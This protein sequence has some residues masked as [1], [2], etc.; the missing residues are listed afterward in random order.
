MVSALLMG[1]T[2][3]VLA[4][5]N[6]ETLPLQDSVSQYGI[7]WT[8]NRKVHVGRFITGDYYAVGPVTVIEI[9]P[10]FANDRNGSMLNPSTGSEQGYGRVVGGFAATLVYNPRLTAKVPIEMKPGDSLVSCITYETGDG[11]ARPYLEGYGTSGALAKTAAVL[12]CLE[13]PVPL[14][15]F[16]PSYCG[17]QAK[18]RRYSDLHTELLLKLAPT[19]TAPDMAKYERLLERPWI[20]HVYGWG[21]REIH[22]ALNMPDYGQSIGRVMSEAALL[23]SCDYPLEKKRKVLIGVVQYGIDL[24]GCIEQG[25]KG[26]PQQGGFGGGRKWPILFA[27]VLLKDE[28]MQKPKAEFAEDQG[29]DFD[30]CWT[31]A[32][33]VFNGHS[34]KNGHGRS[35][36][37]RLRI[38]ASFVV[39]DRHER[40]VPSELHQCFVCGLR[41]GGPPYASGEGL[42]PRRLLRLCGPLDG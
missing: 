4:A 15:T 29:Y 7:T 11:A 5:P 35:R 36:A 32:N 17:H 34:G 3:T 6:L 25:C 16:R 9:T 14:D 30:H 33:V 19:A 10:A 38:P 22:P 37:G 23:L 39:A 8:F 28:A 12:T 41:P 27:G 20:D 13:A 24:W 40:N 1:G 2:E 42:G 18:L 26:W 21:S 31:G